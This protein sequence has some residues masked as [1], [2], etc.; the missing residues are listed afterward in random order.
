MVFVQEITQCLW[1][2]NI[3]F[4]FFFF[5]SSQILKIR[6]RQYFSLV[7]CMK[8]PSYK[9]IF[10]RLIFRQKNYGF[11][12]GNAF[13]RDQDWNCKLFLKNQFREIANIINRVSS[14]TYVG[15]QH[16][17]FVLHKFIMSHQIKQHLIIPLKVFFLL[18]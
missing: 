3:F 16:N 13:D 18:G 1:W 9:K 4:K 10:K 14:F 12:F 17:S 6:W 15:D 8:Y 7:F 11:T 2:T 5:L